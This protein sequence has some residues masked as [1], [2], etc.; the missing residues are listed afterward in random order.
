MERDDRALME[1]EKQSR[2]PLARK[3][4]P[5]LPHSVSE[6]P[7]ERHSDWPA[8]LNAHEIESKNMTIFTRQSAKPLQHRFESRRSPIKPD[9]NFRKCGI[10]DRNAS[11][12][13][14]IHYGTEYDARFEGKM[15]CR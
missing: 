6:T 1:A 10:P 15:I 3:M 5:W 12:S 4:A 8:N 9:R 14:L 11:V 13:I 2:N 7:Y